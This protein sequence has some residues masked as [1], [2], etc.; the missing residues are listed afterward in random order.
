MLRFRFLTAM[1]LLIIVPRV[2]SGEHLQSSP[3]AQPRQDF[4]ES[5]DGFYSQFSAIV[6]AYRAGDKPAGQRLIEQFRLPAPGQ[7]FA[8]H[9]GTDVSAN[10]TERY[11]KLFSRFAAD[12]ERNIS[13]ELENREN[14][15]PQLKDGSEEPPTKL[16][17]S[18]SLSGMKTTK[19]TALF[20]S[21]FQ[22]QRDGRDILS[23]ARAFTFEAGAFRFIGFGSKPFWIWQKDALVPPQKPRLLQQ[24]VL[25]HSVAAVY[26]ASA[27]ANRIQG[28]VTLMLL[29]DNQG[30]VKKADVQSGDPALAQAAIDAARQ[31]RFKPP[32]ENGVPVESNYVA[33]IEFRL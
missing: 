12:L 14:L 30:N 15:Q 25:L 6:E 22:L 17:P 23:W 26:P 29:I 32:I 27:K 8:D 20:Y 24:A 3:A 11:D 7:W 10:L 28:K 19:Q 5:P 9:L 1:L 33:E 16:L 13:D 18:M 21:Q 2:C 4:V 31:W